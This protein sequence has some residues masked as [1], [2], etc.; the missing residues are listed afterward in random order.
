MANIL[1]VDFWKTAYV[2]SDTHWFHDNIV[3]YCNRAEQVAMLSGKKPDLY[4]HNEYMI[5]QW[6]S[7]VGSD[8]II[9]HL[10]DLFCW[11]KQGQFKFEGQV[12]PRLNGNKYLILGNHDKSK[13]SE[14]EQ[15]GFKIID[16]FT[17]E[18]NGLKVSFNHYPWK[19]DEYHDDEI[20][21]HGHIHNGGY[22][23][24]SNWK[25]GVTG[26]SPRQINVSVEVIDYTPQRIID[27]DPRFKNEIS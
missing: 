19:F 20:R 21:I 18:I 12:L 14:Y 9:L 13:P 27:L 10:G 11:F 8:D 2:V 25:D 6:N 1:P 22:P 24:T 3:K 15:M 7:V 17:T 4:A 5:Q 26:T 23:K 16:P